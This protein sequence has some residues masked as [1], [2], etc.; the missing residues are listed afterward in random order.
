MLIQIYFFLKTEKKR[1]GDL[2]NPS[3]TKLVFIFSQVGNS[4]H[5]NKKIKNI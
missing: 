1:G 4:F 2:I 5:H 3:D